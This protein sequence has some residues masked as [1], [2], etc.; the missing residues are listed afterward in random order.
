MSFFSWSMRFSAGRNDR[1]RDKHLVKP[2]D[3]QALYNLP[4]GLEGKYQLLDVYFPK[5]TVEKLPVI[6]NIHG[7][8]YVYGTKE[9]YVAPP[10]TPSVPTTPN[11]N[12]GDSTTTDVPEGG[13][14][15]DSSE[16]TNTETNN[17]STTN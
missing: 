5:G 8:G 15:A 12:T 3:V 13:S 7:G 11:T 6:V 4:Y 17:T 16:N 2:E 10:A 14:G 1:K 9:V